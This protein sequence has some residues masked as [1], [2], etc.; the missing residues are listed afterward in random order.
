MPNCSSIC[1]SDN[2]FSKKKW[3]MSKK[4]NQENIKIGNVMIFFNYYWC[5]IISRYK[6]FLKTNKLLAVCIMSMEKK[7]PE[8]RTLSNVRNSKGGSKVQ[9]EGLIILIQW[10]AHSGVS[11]DLYCDLLTSNLRFVIPFSPEIELWSAYI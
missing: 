3:H 6:F 7:T 8:V 9:P 1:I 5:G 10:L 4:M 11:S 2:S